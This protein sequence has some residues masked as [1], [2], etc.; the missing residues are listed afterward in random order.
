MLNNSQEFG[1]ID[2]ALDV[3]FC[4]KLEKAREIKQ[5]NFKPKALAYDIETDEIKIGEGEILM[6]SLV[7]EGFKKVITW[8]KEKKESKRGK[9][10]DHV[11][12]VKNEADLIEKFVEYVKKLA[13]DFLVGYF[14][15]GF[16][17]P[18]LRARAEKLNVHLSIGLDESQPR[19][20][21]GGAGKDL[22]SAKISGIVHIDLLKFIQTAYSQ[23]MQSETMSLN[24][25]ANEFLGDTKKK[26]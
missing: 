1:G 22:G 18:S 7:S 4:V 15:D 23:Y 16:D 13:P 8:K 14:S 12:Y 26:H 6:V 19:F 21:R 25:V 24:E 17:L 20:F 5:E 10:L 11:E 9:S 3:D 2:M